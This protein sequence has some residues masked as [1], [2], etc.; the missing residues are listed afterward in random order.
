[1]VGIGVGDRLCDCDVIVVVLI[2]VSIWFGEDY[3]DVLD[4]IFLFVLLV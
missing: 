2:L 1:M 3:V 4:G